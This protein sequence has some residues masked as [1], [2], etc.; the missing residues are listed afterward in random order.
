MLKP[1][2]FI[3]K[4]IDEANEKFVDEIVKLDYI[5]EEFKHGVFIGKAK[6]LPIGVKNLLVN[7][8]FLKDQR[9]L[10]RRML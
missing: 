9:I 4:V 3:Q 7:F 1:L 2:P 10:R 8:F 6:N 5:N